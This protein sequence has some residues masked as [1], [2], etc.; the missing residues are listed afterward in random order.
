VKLGA[1]VETDEGRGRVVAFDHRTTWTFGRPVRE[2]WVIVQLEDGR[3]R[4]LLPA[5]VRETPAAT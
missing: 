4:K 3:Q 1:T 5:D 2:T